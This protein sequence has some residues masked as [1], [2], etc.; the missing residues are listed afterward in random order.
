M[1]GGAD[2]PDKEGLLAHEPT[3]EV[4]AVCGAV[5]EEQLGGAVDVPGGLG[6]AVR[7]PAETVFR[8]RWQRQLPTTAPPRRR[9]FV[10]MA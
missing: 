3:E 10:L 7:I 9:L 2:R 8:D 1:L 6:R 4:H 5:V